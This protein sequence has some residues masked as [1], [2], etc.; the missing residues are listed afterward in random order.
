MTDLAAAWNASVGEAAY[1]WSRLDAG[2]VSTILAGL[3]AALA[4]IVA[5][6]GRARLTIQAARDER[7]AAKRQADLGAAFNVTAK[8]IKVFS[9]VR[10][11][12]GVVGVALGRLDEPGF[13][14]A[15]PWEALQPFATLPGE[16]VFTPEET[17]FLLSTGVNAI[18]LRTLEMADVYNDL[19]QHLRLYS[20][21][22]AAFMASMVPVITDGRIDL[23]PMDH[24]TALKVAYITV[25]LQGLFG[26]LV[27]RIDED[28]EQATDI[29]NLLR[30]HCYQRFGRDFPRM[31][32]TGVGATD[33]T[34]SCTHTTGNESRRPA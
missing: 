6:Y 31:E 32:I 20:D 27:S 1:L 8:V 22:R 16:V 19:L 26:S 12:H 28:F 18:M 2:S 25:P 4:A 17:A 33:E 29:L 21:K 9:Y 24:E 13:N 7:L 3:L 10:T 5:A 34:T 11:I 23:P 14:K 30:A 15:R